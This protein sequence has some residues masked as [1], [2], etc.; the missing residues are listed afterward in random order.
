MGLG[1]G[2]VSILCEHAILTQTAR[3]MPEQTWGKRN[4]EVRKLK[5]IF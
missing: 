2:V 3:Q 4:Q 5:S 1:S